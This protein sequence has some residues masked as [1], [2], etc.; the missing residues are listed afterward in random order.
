MVEL[1]LLVCNIPEER[2]L[3]AAM[4]LAA[5]F[6]YYRQEATSCSM[7]VIIYRVVTS[8]HDKCVSWYQYFAPTCS[9]HLQ[10]KTNHV[11]L[12]RGLSLVL[13]KSHLIVP[14]KAHHRYI[15]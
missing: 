8:E 9:Q 12:H 6:V 4:F 15:F 2:I 14:I 11:S 7:A 3:Q 5:M 10:F 1:S 13:F